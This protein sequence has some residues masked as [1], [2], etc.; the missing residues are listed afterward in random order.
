MMFWWI[1]LAIVGTLA[2][3]VVLSAAGA[4]FW[5]KYNL[6]ETLADWL[7]RNHLEQSQLM[8]AFIKIDGY[9]NGFLRLYVTRRDYYVTPQLVATE[10]YITMSNL[11]ADVR[12]QVERIR[13]EQGEYTEMIL[14]N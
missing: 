10:E 7:H 4:Y 3:G 5:K 13:A 11:P 8:N 12:E 9:L 2:A 1:F 6:R 14:Q